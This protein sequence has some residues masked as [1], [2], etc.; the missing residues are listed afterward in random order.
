MISEKPKLDYELLTKSIIDIVKQHNSW[1]R[2]VSIDVETKNLTGNDFLTGERML[3]IGVARRYSSEVETKI[4]RLKDDSDDAEIELMNEAAKFMNLVKP[5]VLVGY[6][7]SGYDFPLLIIKLKQY[8]NYLKSRGETKKYPNEYWALKNALSRTYVLDIMHPL[9][10][11]VARHDQTN[12]KYM[13]LE[14]VVNHPRFS[15]LKLKRLKGLVHASTKEEKGEVIYEMW[16]SK[17]PDFERY[18][19]G[20]VYD[21][22]LLAEELF[23]IKP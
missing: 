22:L 21:V 8:E 4:F 16:E 9:R 23:G 5:L 13:S 2:V 10:F 15:N 20:D 11:E 19:E 3:G 17:N 1:F 6:N 18:L 12:P 7:I 14:E